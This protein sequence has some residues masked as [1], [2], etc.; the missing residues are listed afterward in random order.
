M[1]IM[2]LQLGLI[3][4]T[5]VASATLL[6]ADSTELKSTTD[7]NSYAL[8]MNMGKALRRIGVRSDELNT[9]MLV[10]GLRD[11]QTA[12]N[13]LLTDEQMMQTLRS[14]QI[15][16]RKELDVRNKTEGAAF[17]AANKT[18]E[19]VKTVTVNLSSNKTAELQ[20]KILAEGSGEPPKSNDTVT[21]NYRGT[22]VD[23]TEFD[24]SYKRGKP[25]TFAANRVIRGWS[26]ALTMM[27]PGAHWELFIPPELG[28]GERGAGGAIG[29]DATL[30]FDVEL[31]SVKEPPP[32][33]PAPADNHA[34]QPITSDII[35][36]PSKEEIQKGAKIEVIKASDLEKL[37]AQ[38]KTNAP[39]Q[40][41]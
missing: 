11:G 23:G 40:A 28:Y 2:K 30:I 21:V 34:G 5:A 39:A 3:A 18:K 32:M 19:G 36:V 35:K 9:D 14:L 33:P 20:Y 37:K 24:S 22:L 6:A 13:T 7:T 29:P 15:E 16:A 31:L 4:L 26:E 41:K 1:K 10:R 17:L 38:E 25:A 12:T 8:G 27:K